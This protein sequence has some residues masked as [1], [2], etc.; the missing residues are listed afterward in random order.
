LSFSIAS[1]ALFTCQVNDVCLST[2]LSFPLA[3][4]NK[5]IFPVC[6]VNDSENG[7]YLRTYL[8]GLSEYICQAI[9]GRI[10]QV[11]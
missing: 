3:N 6:D 5:K 10:C 11:I 1:Q 2:L 9:C 8:S 4:D 7:E